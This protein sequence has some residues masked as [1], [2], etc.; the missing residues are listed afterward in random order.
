MGIA[1]RKEREKEQR[2]QD[3]LVAAERVFFAKGFDQ[4]TMDDVAVQAELSKGTLYLYFKSKV[5]LHWEITKKG[6]LRLAE[7]LTKALAT[8]AGGLEK[9]VTMGEV[10]YRFSVDEP[11]YFDS[12]AFFEGKDIEQLNMESGS[13]D[14]WFK[15]SPIRILYDVVESGVRDGTIRNDLP[16]PA[17]ANT[18]WAQ[19]LGVLQVVKNKKEVFEMLS[20]SA[21]EV[22]QC[23]YELL[24]NG[25][26]PKS[27]G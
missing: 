24:L 9:L 20:I 16:V 19:T 13:L 21:E 11:M 18:L 17:V 15:D 3:I 7:M 12:L 26:K 10:F 1:E 22:M 6:M 2:R 4:A 25:V 8:G 27:R 23:H 5:E 14:S